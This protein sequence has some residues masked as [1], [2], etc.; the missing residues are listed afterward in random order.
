MA[1]GVA[2]SYSM[3]QREGPLETFSRQGAL[4]PDA[5]ALHNMLSNKP[6]EE[7]TSLVRSSGKPSRS[8][9]VRPSNNPQT[10]SLV[11]RSPGSLQVLQLTTS[12]YVPESF[13]LL[14]VPG[15]SATSMLNGSTCKAAA[16][17]RS[18]LPVTAGKKWSR[19]GSNIAQARYKAG[20]RLQAKCGRVLSKHCTPA[21]M[22]YSLGVS[23]QCSM[24]RSRCREGLTSRAVA[25]QVSNARFRSAESP[26]IRMPISSGDSVRSLLSAVS[27]V[28]GS[29]R[30][31]S[32]VI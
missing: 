24:L 6:S 28:T 3:D 11:R 31:A 15:P 1:T 22:L 21:T 5:I 4:N 26:R 12:L 14:H 9:G 19:P 10:L 32:A 8:S 25:K 13:P 23:A 16:C 17:I 29:C 7:P 30:H 20:L 27:G 18:G 2:L